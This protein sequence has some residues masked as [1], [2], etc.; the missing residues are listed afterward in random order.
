MCAPLCYAFCADSDSEYDGKRGRGAGAGGDASGEGSDDDEVQRPGAKASL[1]PLGRGQ[2]GTAGH[3]KARLGRARRAR[4][5]DD[6]A[7]SDSD[8]SDDGGRGGGGKRAGDR[9][10][11]RGRG[12]KGGRQR[13]YEVSGRRARDSKEVPA[14]GDGEQIGEV[15]ANFLR[16]MGAKVADEQVVASEAFKGGLLKRKLR[17]F[18]SRRLKNLANQ[19]AT[20]AMSGWTARF[21]R[22]FVIGRAVDSTERAMRSLMVLMIFGGVLSVMTETVVWR[23]SPDTENVKLKM[24]MFIEAVTTIAYIFEYFVRL[25]VCPVDKNFPR[26]SK[27]P[28]VKRPIYGRVMF[29]LRGDNLLDILLM[30]VSVWKGGRALWLHV[31]VS[32][33]GVCM[34]MFMWDA[35]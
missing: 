19:Q 35:S 14:A 24:V 31:V 27:P 13:D 3:A 1:P 22:V 28:Y 32:V 29:A 2:S 20:E 7:S 17:Q 16:G 5:D 6:E 4:G 30:A 10:R 18:S 34:C 15:G 21:Y 33:V 26:E 12:R 25:V 8:E 11:E 23:E 9:G